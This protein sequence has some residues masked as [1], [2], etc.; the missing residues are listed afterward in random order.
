MMKKFVF[1][2]VLWMP[3]FVFASEDYSFSC[4]TTL[5]GNKTC[6][7]RANEILDTSLTLNLELFNLE[8]LNV[9]LS[10]GYSYVLEEDKIVFNKQS[11]G[12]SIF[13]ATFLFHV[14]E[15]ETSSKI[16]VLPC[17]EETCFAK[18]SLEVPS[19]TGEVANPQ[20]GKFLPYSVFIFGIVFLVFVYKRTHQKSYLYHL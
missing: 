3:F 2:L 7:L 4:E 6:T 20:S 18:T 16:S 15:A 17:E 19:K 1:F 9:N 10:D 14:I 13:E 8:L 5:D 12:T 11:D